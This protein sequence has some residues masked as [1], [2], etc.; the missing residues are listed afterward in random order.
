[1]PKI[2]THRVR[3]KFG[4]QRYQN[5]NSK[6][7]KKNKKTKKIK[8]GGEVNNSNHVISKLSLF[9]LKVFKCFQNETNKK[10][11]T[12]LEYIQNVLKKFNKIALKKLEEKLEEKL[13]KEL[14]GELEEDFCKNYLLMLFLKNNKLLLE[15]SKL[16]TIEYIITK[17]FDELS[18]SLEFESTVECQI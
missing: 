8:R 2:K 10:N 7:I 11:E 16:N 1:M 3:L 18:N 9:L 17:N 6:R 14:N 13:K 4:T 12:T 5:K 15:N